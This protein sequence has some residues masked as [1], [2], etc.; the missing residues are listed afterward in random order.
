MR[1]AVPAPIAATVATARG[2]VATARPDW[3][4]LLLIA[5]DALAFV[6]F[7][8]IG[9]RSHG[10][11]VGLAALGQVLWTAA[12]FALGWFAVAPFVGAFRRKNTS[13][14]RQLLAR[15]E[16][17]WVAAWPI[18]LVLRWA[19]AEDHQVPLSFALV[20]LIANA[21]LLGAW[22]TLFVLGTH[23]AGV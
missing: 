19:L 15:T 11:V 1:P 7:A 13:R 16:L 10:E 22:R 23:R 17:A 6:V 5:G 9:R 2:K 4:A 14:P 3:R 21:I 8:A 18:T 12:P 20:I